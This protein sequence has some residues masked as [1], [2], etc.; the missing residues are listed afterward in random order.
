[1]EA[2][3]HEPTSEE[4]RVA[5]EAFRTLEV[6]QTTEPNKEKKRKLQVS[7]DDTTTVTIPESAL[8]FLVELLHQMSR[9]KAITLL[10]VDSE[11]STQQAADM[12][13]VSRPHLVKLLEEGKIPFTK[14]GKHRR[15]L[16]EDLMEYKEKKAQQRRD[17]LKKLTEEAQNLDVEY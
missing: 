1:M 7:V 3:L 9:G 17:S 5:E 4:K 2:V 10:P 8:E 11:L 6:L 15:I 16:T 12:L 13:N 14:V